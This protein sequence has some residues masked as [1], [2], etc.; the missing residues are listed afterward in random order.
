VARTSSAAPAS[1]KAFSSAWAARGVAASSWAES[2]KTF[3]EAAFVFSA[4]LWVAYPAARWLPGRL[5]LLINQ[6]SHRHM[7]TEP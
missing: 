3:G 6:A 5:S 1:L 4:F 2:S 7:V